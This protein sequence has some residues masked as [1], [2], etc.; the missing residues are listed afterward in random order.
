MIVRLKINILCF[1]VYQ[2]ESAGANKTSGCKKQWNLS[3]T[4]SGLRMHFSGG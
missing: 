1:V 2:G 4:W 3:W